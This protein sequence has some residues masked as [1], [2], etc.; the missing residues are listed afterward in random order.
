M[1][2]MAINQAGKISFGSFAL[3]PRKQRGHNSRRKCRDG[4]PIEKTQS[5]LGVR[6]LG[7]AEFD[8][9]GGEE[10]SDQHERQDLAHG[11]ER[12]EK[13]WRRATDR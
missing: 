4:A 7:H 9:H 6:R 2:M 5:S 1:R 10:T 8:S 3:N 11:I 12:R 13:W